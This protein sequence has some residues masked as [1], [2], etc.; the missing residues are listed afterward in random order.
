MLLYSELYCDSQACDGPLV[1]RKSACCL[2]VV[3]KWPILRTGGFLGAQVSRGIRWS[4]VLPSGWWAR[5]LM[6]YRVG[7]A[8][9]GPFCLHVT[10][11]MWSEG[12]EQQTGHRAFWCQEEEVL[13]AEGIQ[14]K[15]SA[16]DGTAWA[17]GHSVWGEQAAT[18]VLR[19]SSLTKVGH[20]PQQHFL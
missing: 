18:E 3:V 9:P 8:E 11:G 7:Q 4:T 19:S 6:W 15:P 14:E 20:V 1:P 10:P 2:S 13:S 17:S 12:N 5:C 16:A